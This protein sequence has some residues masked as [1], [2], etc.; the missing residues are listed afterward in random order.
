MGSRHYTREQLLKRVLD[1]I[2]AGT[3]A[4]RDKP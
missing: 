4:L 1:L 3:R 2:F